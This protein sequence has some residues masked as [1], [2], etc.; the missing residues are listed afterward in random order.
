MATNLATGLPDPDGVVLNPEH[1]LRTL[2]DE[3]GIDGSPDLRVQGMPAL[4]RG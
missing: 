2:Y 3:V 4:M 1:I